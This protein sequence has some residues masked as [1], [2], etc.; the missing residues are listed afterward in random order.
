MV[1]RSPQAHFE[2]RVAEARQTVLRQLLAWERDPAAADEAQ[3]GSANK[4]LFDDRIYV[5]TPGGEI[6]D[7]PSGALAR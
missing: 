2:R 6:I 4:G 7:L 1:G 5:F 3:G